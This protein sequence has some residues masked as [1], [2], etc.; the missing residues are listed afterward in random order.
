MILY[1][2]IFNNATFCSFNTTQFLYNNCDI[3]RNDTHTARTVRTTTSGVPE[4][5]LKEALELRLWP[6]LIMPVLVVVGV[7]AHPPY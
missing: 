4:P 2:N 3:N 6:Q 7:H 5:W 1:L